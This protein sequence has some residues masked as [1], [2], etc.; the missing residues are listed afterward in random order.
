MDRPRHLA[1]LAAALRRA[2]LVAILGPR[3][4][5]KTTLARQLARQRPESITHFDLEDPEDL[6]QLADAKLALRELRGLVI[7]DEIQRRPELFPVLRV[8]ADRRPAPAK[9][10]VLGSASPELLRQGSETLAGRIHY[11]ELTP[12]RLDETG[13]ANAGRLWL[14]GGFPRSYLARSDAE[15]AAWRRDFIATYLERDVP[16]FGARIPAETLHRFWSM[17]AHYHGQIWA[18]SEF[19]RSFGM[20]DVT[21]RRYLDLLSS[22][23]LVRQLAPWHENI[24]KRLVKSPKVYVTD[25]GLVHQLLGIET[26]PSLLRHPKLGASWEGFALAAVEARLGARRGESYFYATHGGAELDLLVVRGHRRLGFEFKRT[27]APEFTRSM[28]VA[29]A[30]L[31][32]D[33]LEVIH[34]GE[35]TFPLA[36]RVRAVPLARILQDLK[37][38]PGS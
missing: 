6:R 27:T 5:G 13:V 17:L 24:G 21:V 36:D 19:A 38:L 14:R 7:L 22:L 31:R 15:S 20:S 2:P 16:Q 3:Q 34:A 18:S 30:D 28:R 29:L 12:F 25:T 32:L 11:H 9:F 33:R 23:F 37:P 8:L 1:A 10:L 35:H 4:I 26:L